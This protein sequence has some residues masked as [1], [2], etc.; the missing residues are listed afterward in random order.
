MTNIIFDLLKI[1]SNDDYNV[2]FIHNDRNAIRAVEIY[3]T[4][5]GCNGF[6]WISVDEEGEVEVSF[7]FLDEADNRKWNQ[8]DAPTI[9]VIRNFFTR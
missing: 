6:V 7:H 5:D 3:I 4:K 8:Y 1:I 2:D 9:D